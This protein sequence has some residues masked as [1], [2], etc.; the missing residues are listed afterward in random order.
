MGRV[1][2]RSISRSMVFVSINLFF[3]LHLGIGQNEFEIRT[4]AFRSRQV[5][6]PHIAMCSRVSVAKWKG[7][8]D[9]HWS[10]FHSKRQN[11]FVTGESEDCIPTPSQALTHELSFREA[12]SGQ[13]QSSVGEIRQR[14]EFLVGMRCP[15]N[16][17]K[18]C[19]R[20]VFEVCRFKLST[21]Y[22]TRASR[23]IV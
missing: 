5:R 22:G 20:S 8:L 17:L 9:H 11:A 15:T 12:Y 1:R 13:E 7:G 14:F 18:L 16:A 19:S 4:I 21:G 2:G 23:D 10:V 6:V 3:G